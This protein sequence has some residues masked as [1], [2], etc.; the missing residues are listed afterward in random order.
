[1]LFRVC[2]CACLGVRNKRR[3]KPLD[4]WYAQGVE[5][6]WGCER[7]HATVTEIGVCLSFSQVTG[8]LLLPQWRRRERRGGGR[9][10]KLWGSVF[11]RHRVASHSLAGYTAHATRWMV[12]WTYHTACHPDKL[13]GLHLKRSFV[14]RR[15]KQ[16]TSLV[17]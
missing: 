4:R 7:A 10:L 1:M 14:W 17:W 9:P 11:S 16:L 2:L 12:C 8:A 3:N 6:G 15:E 5:S 13:S